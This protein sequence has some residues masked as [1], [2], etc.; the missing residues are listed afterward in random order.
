MYREPLAPGVGALPGRGPLIIAPVLDVMRRS[1]VGEPSLAKMPDAE[2]P[3]MA[4]GSPPVA[5]STN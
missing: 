5:A 3:A 4:H 1:A 2:S